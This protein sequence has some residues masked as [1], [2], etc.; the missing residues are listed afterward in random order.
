MSNKLFVANL[1]WSMTEQELYQLFDAAGDVVSVRIPTDRDSGRPRG[2]AFVEMAAP[3]AAQSAIQLLHGKMVYD[4][5]MVVTIQDENKSRPSGGSSSR[6]ASAESSKLFV[7]NVAYSVTE[8]D[9]NELFARAGSVVSVKI[10]TDRDTYQPKGFAFVEMA[11]TVEAKTAITQLNGTTLGGKA[12]AIDFQDPNRGARTKPA[13]S[14]NSYRGNH[15]NQE[16]SNA[17]RW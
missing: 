8:Q 1:S 9:L 13:R 14:G 4:R 3:D 15:F 10:P 5:E 11:S 16:Y 12:L 6:G 17:S 2:F 7:R